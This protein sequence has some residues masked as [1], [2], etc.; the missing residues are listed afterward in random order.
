V[1]LRQTT[2]AA[3]SGSA[4]DSKAGAMASE[5]AAGATDS[6]VTRLGQ[7]VRVRVRVR[8]RVSS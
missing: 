5:A 7:K 1:W 8:V 6:V 3:E 4:L 2:L